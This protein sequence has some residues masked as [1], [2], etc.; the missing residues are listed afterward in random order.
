VRPQSHLPL[1]N[2]D[3]VNAIRFA[4]QIFSPE[5]SSKGVVRT[6]MNNL[7]FELN[8]NKPKAPL[9]VPEN[10]WRFDVPLQISHEENPPTSQ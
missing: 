6:K 10:R 5:A 8:S 3:E 7:K 9:P 4:Q 1:F 2:Q